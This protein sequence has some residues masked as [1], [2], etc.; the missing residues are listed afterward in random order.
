MLLAQ[1]QRSR[2]AL[3]KRSTVP[4]TYRGQ[5]ILSWLRYA[6][7]EHTNHWPQQ[8]YRGDQE[9]N[10]QWCDTVVEGRL[11]A[12]LQLLFMHASVM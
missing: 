11:N 1:C 10:V 12:G 8:Y 4:R 2:G 3:Q 9:N 6:E 5:N 7:S